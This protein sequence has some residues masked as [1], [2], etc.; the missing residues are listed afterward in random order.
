[1]AAWRRPPRQPA[2]SFSN[3]LA[4]WMPRLPELTG[5]Q[6]HAAWKQR[7]SF[8][9]SGDP[10]GTQ[11]RDCNPRTLLQDW[12]ALANRRFVEPFL[13]GP[14]QKLSRILRPCSAAIQRWISTANSTIDRQ[15]KRALGAVQR[16][17]FYTRCG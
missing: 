12:P 4:G 1:M 3:R 13:K 6:L 16:S 17:R 9:N 5:N 11:H 15:S 10:L 2:T 7:Q 14:L 8:P